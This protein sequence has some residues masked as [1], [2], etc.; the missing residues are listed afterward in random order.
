M[1]LIRQHQ[2][3]LDN[4]KQH[5]EAERK[6]DF[7]SQITDE[8]S[9]R[10]IDKIVKARRFQIESK[11]KEIKTEDARNRFDRGFN[12]YYTQYD[13]REKIRAGAHDRLVQSDIMQNYLVNLKEDEFKEAREM[14]NDLD[15][16]E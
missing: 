2:D 5:I 9:K 1:D 15:K 16:M 12:K 3:E 11:I 14:R 10:H 13:Q 4:L 6:D 8:Q 7:F